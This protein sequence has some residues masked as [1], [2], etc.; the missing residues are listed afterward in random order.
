MAMTVIDLLWGDADQAREILH[1][2]RP[3]LSKEK[4]LAFLDENF[5]AEIYDGQTGKS[6]ET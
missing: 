6:E 2:H 5:K 3:A 1:K 4:Y